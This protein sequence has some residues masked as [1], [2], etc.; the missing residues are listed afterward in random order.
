[1]PILTTLVM[2]LTLAGTCLAFPAQAA[3]QTSPDG[4]DFRATVY[5]Y[6]PRLD[7]TIR[8]G[9][10]GNADIEITPDMLLDKTNL[11]LMG[12]YEMHKGRLGG[13]VDTMYFNLASGEINASGFVSATLDVKAWTMTLGGNIR[14]LSRPHVRLDVFGGARMFKARSQLRGDITSQSDSDVWDGIGGVKGRISLG[15]GRGVF[16]PYYADAGAGQSDLTL[17]AVAGLGY[18][19]R[20]VEVL[21]VWRLLR[22]VGKPESRVE[23]LNFSGPTAGVAFRW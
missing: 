1:V 21:G 12:G 3:A 23:A 20:H 6:L 22:Y 18:A 10:G 19:L 14:A 8:F 11:A 4:F 2:V 15:A 5:G 17:Q 16:L 9:N 7:G 13:F